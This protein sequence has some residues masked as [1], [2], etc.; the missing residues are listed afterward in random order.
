MFGC[1]MLYHEQSI[2]IST[3]MMIQSIVNAFNLIFTDSLAKTNTKDNKRKQHWK[4]Q[5]KANICL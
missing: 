3:M 2:S 5:N 1:L 4:Y